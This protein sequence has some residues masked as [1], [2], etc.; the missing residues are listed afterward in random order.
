[1]G[2][3]QANLAGDLS[4]V[5]QPICDARTRQVR[6]SEAL[7]RWTGP[8][9]TSLER[10]IHRAEHT[11][12]I[13]HL[14]GWVLDH[15][16]EQAHR[17]Q[18]SGMPDLRLSVNVSP[19]QLEDPAFPTKAAALLSSHDLEPSHVELEIT[20]TH[21]RSSVTELA[22]V[23]ERLHEIGVRV[24]LDDLGS[25]E[26]SLE[27]LARLPVDTV[28]LDARFSANLE[29]SRLQRVTEAMIEVSHRLG[30]EVIAEGVETEAQLAWFRARGCD[31]IQGYVLARPMT[32]QEMTQRLRPGRMVLAGAGTR[33][34]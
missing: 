20:E 13:H 10:L 26:C 6:G 28:K 9:S 17:W 2:R 3:I 18:E 7:L 27:R 34:G 12:A 23:C 29:V 32:A 21:A 15:A 14:G 22:R 8:Q 19:R 24:A 5:Y 16:L 33:P 30:C 31:L 25:G 1:M 11:G 4:L